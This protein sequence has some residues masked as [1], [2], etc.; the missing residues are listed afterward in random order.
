LNVSKRRREAGIL[1]RGEKTGCRKIGKKQDS[2]RGHDDDDGKRGKL[3]FGEVENPSSRD[4]E[5]PSKAVPDSQEWSEG[6]WSFRFLFIF[7]V[8]D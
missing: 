7:S 1:R 4:R 5:S 8:P 6:V 2:F 3:E